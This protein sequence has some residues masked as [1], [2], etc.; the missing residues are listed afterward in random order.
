MNNSY[1]LISI[2]IMA[3]IT[4]LIRAI[5]MLV[6]KSKIQNEFVKSFIYYVPY[7]VLTIMTFPA[8]LYS[9]NYVL[10]ALLGTIV[11]LFLAYKGL[12]LVKTMILAGI[13]V[14]LVEVLINCM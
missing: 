4:Y 10:S 2:A 5:P 11:A 6:F 8:I 12:G 1:I 9:T 3:S 7:V 13:F 14:Y